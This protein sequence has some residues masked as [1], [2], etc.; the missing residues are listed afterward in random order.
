MKD[1][2]NLERFIDA[3][4]DIFNTVIVELKQGKKSGHWMWYVFP[5]I[6][7]L[8]RSPTSICFAITSIA[9]ARSYL[10]HPILG[11]RLRTCTDLVN[12]TEGRTAEQI[13]GYPDYLKFR[14]SMTLF[15]YVDEESS[16]FSHAL[17]RF[18]GGEP[19]PRTL[20]I[21]DRL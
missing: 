20:D 9:E 1:P 12:G 4:R 6:Q 5:Q 8:G 13:F 15:E 17:R 2:Y 21:L 14:S 3:Q 7:G 18:F 16:S 11:N 19:D 10:N